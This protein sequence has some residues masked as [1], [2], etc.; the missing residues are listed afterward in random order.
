MSRLERRTWVWHFSEPPERLWP[1]LS[2]TARL[3]EAAKFPTYRVEDVVQE[4]GSVEHVA[5]ATVAGL[6]L[7][8]EEPPYEW[9]RDRTFSHTRLFR[10][11][12]LKRFGPLVELRPENGG[13]RVTCT[14]QGE[15]HGILGTL[16]FRLGFLRLAGEGMGRLLASAAAYVAGERASVYDYAPRSL[17][18]GAAARVSA[19]VAE[20]DASAYG[21]GLAARLGSHLL[22]AQD[23]DLAHMRP[24]QLARA[25]RVEPRLAVEL[26]L[27][28]V[29]VGLLKLS[30]DLLCPRCRGAKR[31]VAALDQ[32]P[33]AAHCTSCNIAYDADFARNVELS[34]SPAT[35][36]RELAVGEYCLSGPHATPHVVV[37]QLLQPGEARDVAASLAPGPYRL[38][39]LAPG[40][41]VEIEHAGGGFPSIVVAGISTATGE[42]AP[43]GMLRLVNRGSRPAGIVIESRAWIADALT[44]H[45]AT[46]FQAFRDLL[47]DQAL[48]P[49]ED[50]A[51]DNVTLLFTDLAGST[52]LYE[53]VGDG[54]AYRVVRDHFA[55]LAASVRSHNGALVKTIGDSVMAAFSEPADAVRAA[56]EVQD[57][58]HAFNAAHGEEAITIK[59]GLHGGP[60]IAVTMNDRLDYFG[61]AVNMAA[62]LQGQSRGGDVVLSETLAADPA[63]G[64]LLDGRLATREEALLKGMTRAVPFRRIEGAA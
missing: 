2:D 55:F 7:E 61:S 53:R 49:D 63:V 19:R 44:A 9:V 59:I 40:G 30:W 50:I 14:L 17:P 37:Q 24:L 38:R 60:C 64:P 28:A 41:E 62:R 6:A 13:T 35:A 15:P 45:R 36:V 56:L 11:G 25:W 26:F 3:N 46:T 39:T 31:S 43:L 21:H 32:L 51:I 4:D 18:A 33:K 20:I 8:W 54:P 52:A 1:L 47:P 10:K 27:E 22:T 34:F 58:V 48:R 29:R 57:N 42:M 5:R 23:V 12:P 16:L